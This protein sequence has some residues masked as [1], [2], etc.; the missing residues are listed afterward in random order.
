MHHR[1]KYVNYHCPNC[2]QTGK[3]PNA[4]GRFYLINNICVCN[5]CNA[6]YPKR[7]IYKPVIFHATLTE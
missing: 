3:L 4:G 6:I 1:P 5:G 7:L 2:M